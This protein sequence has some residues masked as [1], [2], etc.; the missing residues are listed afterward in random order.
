[1]VLYLQYTVRAYKTR[2]LFAFESSLPYP[3]MIA[4]LVH[5]FGIRVRAEAGVNDPR[6]RMSAAPLRLEEALRLGEYQDTSPA[7]IGLQPSG[8]GNRAY[9]KRTTTSSGDW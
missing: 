2:I 3:A 8:T 1:M 7:Q 9:L 4:A 6:P 5:L